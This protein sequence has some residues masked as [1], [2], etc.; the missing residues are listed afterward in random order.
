MATQEL[1]HGP[2]RF[3]SPPGS[4]WLFRNPAAGGIWLVVRL[5]VGWQWLTAGERKLFGGSS[6]GWVHGGVVKGKPVHAGDN[7]LHFWQHAI[8][9][10]PPGAMPQVA[11][12]WYRQFLRF[13][14]EHHTQS[15][16]AHLIAWGE[17]LVG[18]GLLLG[19]FTAVTACCGALLNL[20]Y[21][22]AGSASLNPVLFLGAALLVLAW[23]IAGV[24]GLDRWLLPLLGTPWQPGWLIQRLRTSGSQSGRVERRH[25]HAA[26]PP[27]V[28]L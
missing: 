5:W 4:T 2:S 27:P 16:F 12:G 21:M 9:P 18:V 19:A 28:Y 22:L 24:I 1:I 6:A 23:R 13:L 3:R 14:I 10:A 8:T 20:N 7:L 11:F 17:L 26:L 15:W 25:G